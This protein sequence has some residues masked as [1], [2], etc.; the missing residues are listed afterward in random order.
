MG[1]AF[2]LDPYLKELEEGSVEPDQRRTVVH[3]WKKA[4]RTAR[5]HL[6][7][8][9]KAFLR[10]EMAKCARHLGIVSHYITDG[11]IHGT[12]DHFSHSEDHSTVEGEIG[13]RSDFTSGLVDTISEGLI[14]G[15]FVFQDIDGLVKEGLN[16]EGLNRALSLLGSTVLSQADP[17]LEV[18]E[19]NRNFS[20]RIRGGPFRL[21]G[22][23]AGT[24]GLAAWALT[25]DPLYVLLLA[26]FPL[27]VGSSA[28]F[29]LLAR[30]GWIP[31]GGAALGFIYT[32]SGT[33]GGPDWGRGL[34]VLAC[35]GLWLYLTSIPD[36]ARWSVRWYQ[37]PRRNEETGEEQPEKTA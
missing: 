11:M 32:L 10:N 6:Y 33:A 22:A 4:R 35:L 3:T 23:A 5:G 17:P 8:A 28:V 36:L 26:F 2:G 31:A 9:R 16:P 29:R 14:D 27:L 1:T 37:M 34:L 12:M 20:R 24:L 21:A 7:R 15:E 18:L 13:S 30:W 25:R 19:S